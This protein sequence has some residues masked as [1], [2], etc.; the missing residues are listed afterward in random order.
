MSGYAAKA[1]AVVAAALALVAGGSGFA[2]QLP[3]PS[4]LAQKD[5]DAR[6]ISYVEWLLFQGVRERNV[7][8]ITAALRAGADPDKARNPIG[9]LPALTVAVS[10]S[11]ASVPVVSLLIEHGADVNRRWAPK[12]DCDKPDLTPS[13]RLACRAGV[14]PEQ[15]TSHFPLYQAARHSNAQ[16]VERLLKSG[17]DVR[18]RVSN[19]NTALHATFN[20]EI[21]AVLLRYG[22]D[23]NA[24]NKN[25]QTPLANAKRVLAQYEK[26][27]QHPM[28]L[29]MEAFYA[30]L[31][32]QGAAE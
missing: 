25:G 7:D 2:Q 4:P 26:L 11:S 27:P 22:A 32:S 8:Y 31:K 6:G 24:K 5:L 23:V 14:A 10:S 18:A 1:A 3:K 30:W 12:I 13:Q 9:D 28:R 15:P 21:G 29:K 16:V 20:V 17:A 19:G